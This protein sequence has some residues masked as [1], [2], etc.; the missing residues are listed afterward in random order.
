MRKVWTSLSPWRNRELNMYVRWSA[1]TTL[2]RAA[3]AGLHPREK[4]MEVFR[5]VLRK[6]IQ[7]RDDDLVT[8][9]VCE[10]S[11][12]GPKEAMDEIN[13]RLCG[14]SRR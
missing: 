1:V 3:R 2:T 14:Q 11:D 5:S 12:L 10:L 6:A 4:I 8:G 7:T 13:G 9:L